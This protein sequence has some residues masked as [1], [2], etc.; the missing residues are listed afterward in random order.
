MNGEGLA[1]FMSKSFDVIGG[2]N[3]VFPLRH[4]VN[5]LTRILLGALT[6]G[7]ATYHQR[8][9][10]HLTGRPYSLNRRAFS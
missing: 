1:D 10:G 9:L 5:R 7:I 3:K 8:L 6:G 4:Q 2:Q